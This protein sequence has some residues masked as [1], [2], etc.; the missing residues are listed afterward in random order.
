MSKPKKNYVIIGQVNCEKCEALCDI[1]EITQPTKK[2]LT[3]YCYWRE[4]YYCN[5]CGFFGREDYNKVINDPKKLS[6]WE[7]VL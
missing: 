6:S 5:N 4:W 1:K 2:Q 3:S 7:I